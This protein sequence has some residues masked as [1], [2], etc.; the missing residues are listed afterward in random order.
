MAQPGRLHFLSKDFYL[1]VVALFSTVRI[2][3]AF[4][5]DVQF[6]VIKDGKTQG[7]LFG[8]SV[9]LHKQTTGATRY[10]L[11]TGAPKEKA[12]PQL[13]V[14]ETGAVYSCPMTMDP[15]DCSRMD[16][17]NSVQSDEIVEGMWLGVTVARQ[18]DEWGGRV[19]ACGHRYIRIINPEHSQLWRMIGKCYVRGNDLTYDPDDYWQNFPYESCDPANDQFTEGLC[20]MGISGGITQTDVYAGSPGSYNWQGNVQNTWRDSNPENA[21]DTNSRSFPDFKNKSYSYMGYSV[22]EEKGLLSMDEDTL[23]TGSP[24]DDNRG[25]VT[26]AKVEY[27]TLIPMTV[28]YGEQVGSYFGNSIVTTDLNNDGWKDL[29]VGAPFYFNR[30][31]EKGGAVYVFMNENGHYRTDPSV[32]LYGFAG[33]A[34]GMS[35]A[36]IGDINQD[37]FQD[38]AVGAPFHGSGKVFI[39]TGGKEGIAKEPSQVIEGK[40][41]GSG[42]FHTFGYSITGGMDMDQNQYPDVLVGSLDNRIALLRARPVLHLD[43]T[44]SVEP[45]LVDPRDCANDS[46][47]VTVTLCFSYTLSNGD[48]DFKENIS[49]REYTVEADSAMR[50]SRLRFLDNKQDRLTGFLSMPSSRCQTLKL[51]LVEHLRDKLQPVVFSVK[52]SLY[53]GKA[54]GGQ[55]LQ[56]LDAFPVLDKGEEMVEKTEIH[57]QKECG[58]D[59]RCLSN[60]QLTATF[61]NEQQVPFPSQGGHQI[62][63][64]NTGVKKLWLVVDVTNLPDSGNLA[65]DAH[66]AVLNITVPSALHFSGVRS[67]DP[68]VKCTLE[69]TLLC[70]LGNPFESNHEASILI[71]FQ[72]SGISLNTREIQCT[73][74]LSTLSEQSDLDPKPVSLMVEYTLPTTFTVDPHAIQ[75]EFSGTV[76]GESAMKT[77]DDIGS[78]VAYT[79]QVNVE[80]TPLGALGHLEVEFLWPSEVSNGK[81][82]LYLTEILTEGVSGSHCNPPGDIVNL[83]KLNVSESSARRK[84][85]A[86]DTEPQKTDP[87]KP[88]PQA[89]ITLYTLQRENILLDCALGVNVHCVKFTCPLEN[90]NNSAQVTVSARVW[91]GTMLEDYPHDHVTVKGQATL[92]LVTD[93]PTIRMDSQT[94]EFVVT[95]DPKFTDKPLYQVPLWII[96][97]SVL[98]GV[99]LL[100][101]III[102]LW[103]CGFFRR[104]NRRELYE[105][106]ALKAE[107]KIQPSENERLTEE[108]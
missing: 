67:A 13:R 19:L 50:S 36:A 88:D 70:E 93:S 2:C 73:L 108:C 59:N 24:R 34:F 69:G 60:L 4:N 29:V 35:V 77:F 61:T 102:L 37:G 9:A 56:N 94:R 15:S 16:L 43:K 8:L 12:Q 14:N 89:A 107:M 40:E 104:A 3:I 85:E 74:Q 33:S 72:T 7:S 99:L 39:W 101:L 20:N 81:W 58:Q 23:V 86:D 90:M 52:V 66:Q 46:P 64:F 30:K 80:G 28:I 53:E 17:V 71:I 95:I 91:N 38:F 106:K 96:I 79:F 57:F 21:W 84:R 51:S 55:T 63:Q 92:K 97:I 1:L 26:L 6:P 54:S 105:A 31:E 75:T 25:S 78:P 44:F 10:L 27:A 100:S 32:T 18:R 76:M 68:E 48:K 22:T 87:Q 41:V 47:C 65:E 5:L 62:M 103:K 82:L 83:L 45:A 11:L 98:A 42:G 49:D